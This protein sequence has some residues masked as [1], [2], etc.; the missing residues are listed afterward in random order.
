MN[1]PDLIP[2]I[3]AVVFDLDGL[4]VNTE[5]VFSLSGRQLLE[6]RGLQMTDDIHR[7][8]LGRRPNEAFAALKTLTGI[9]DDI[10]DLKR[11]TRELFWTIAE[12]HLALMPG[13]TELLDL[14]EAAGLPRAVATS[15]PRDFLEKLLGRFNLRHRFAVTLTAEDVTHGKPHPEIYLTAAA[16]LNVRTQ[17]IL[18]LE[19]SETG[20]RAAAAAG[21][22]TVSVPNS[23][24][25]AGDFSLA[26]MCVSSLQASE[27]K[28]LIGSGG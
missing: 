20:T 11:E 14:I 12:N 15:S 19:D 28:R 18:V 5:D 6:R 2:A 1:R 9:A 13:L 8:M 21:A 24:T 26:S 22:V 10:E 27:L 25:E 7:S 4:M 3:H 23:H 17:N 16:L